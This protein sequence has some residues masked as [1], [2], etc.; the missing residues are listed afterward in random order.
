MYGP[1]LRELL[2]VLAE[3]LPAKKRDEIIRTVGQRMAAQH[4]SAVKAHR[5]EDRVSEA[6]ALLGD[7]G[8]ACQSERDD[9]KLIVR[10]VDCPLLVAA[11]GHPEVCRLVETM[12]AGLLDVNVKQ[13]CNPHPSP[14]CCF[15]IDGRAK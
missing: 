11:V 10:C 14:Q 3:S 6:I 2:E 8:G 15:E 12:L 1:V 9:G 4:R 5:L 13:N 7:A